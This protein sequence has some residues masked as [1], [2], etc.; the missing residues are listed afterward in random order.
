MRYG[1][2]RIAAV[3]A[4]LGMLTFSFFA[5]RNYFDRLNNHVLKKTKQEAFAIANLPKLKSIFSAPVLTEQLIG[6]DLT[7]PELMIHIK[8]PRQQAR[9]ATT[10]ASQ[11]VTQGRFEPRALI[12]Q[13]LQ[14][15]DSVLEKLPPEGNGL[16]LAEGL[17]L[18]HDHAL[19]NG[20][21]CYFNTDP[22]LLELAK[23][24]ARRSARFVLYIFQKQPGDFSDIQL[25]NLALENGINYK[26]F[27]RAELDQLL[28]LLSPLEN[29]SR[30][31]W[32]E[33]NY[34][35]SKLLIR[36]G[37]SYGN[38]F[39][40]L[41]QEL[42]YLYA[43]SGNAERALQC[44]DTLLK[45]TEG[46]SQN[47]YTEQIDNASNIAPVFYTYQTTT[48]LDAYVSGYCQRKK[49]S[50]TEFYNR[51]VTRTLLGHWSTTNQINYYE[52]NTQLFQNSNLCFS[53]DSLL[54]FFYTKLKAEAVKIR[55]PAE[56]SG[57]TSC[58]E[59]R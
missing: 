15:A 36:G 52:Y 16:K 47:D 11:L 35:S 44:T 27:T 21:A 46:Y 58:R 40:G 5:V 54:S 33:K 25:L 57:R 24:N 53:G 10:I 3:L 32:V 1:P 26:A 13:C 42:A 43:A 51:L 2:K 29:P 49:I 38:K 20:F 23:R 48:Q 34:V 18:V 14:V 39:N 22:A 30:S 45:Y 59:R 8:D 55:Y 50:S 37:Y 7:V 28:Q 56:K 41:F 6:G 31:T 17:K 12:K 9:I 4:G 19:V